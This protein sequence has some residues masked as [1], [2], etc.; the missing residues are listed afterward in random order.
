[1][2]TYLPQWAQPSLPLD[3]GLEDVLHAWRVH[4]LARGD[5]TRTIE[6]RIYTIRR[7][8]SC[9]I[10]PLTTD[11][12]ALLEWL[13]R[14]T[15]HRTGDAVRRSTRATY[16]S[17][18]RAFFRWAKASGRRDDDPSLELPSARAPRGVPRPTTPEG[19]Q[20]ILQACADS[21]AA[22]T[23]AYVLLGAY[24]GLRVHEIAQIRGEDCTD[25]LIF[26]TGKGGVESSIPMHP[27]VADLARRMPPTGP[28]FPGCD[29]GHVHRCSVSSAIKRAMRRAGVTG[30]PHALRHHYG[31]QVLRTSGDLRTAQRALRHASPAST[32]IYTQVADDALYRAIAG[33][34]A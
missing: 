17:Q 30:T 15:D 11:A 26:V 10:D 14:L 9:G 33:I 8:R 7:L 16:R 2:D 27:L 28:W 24:A 32:A 22:Q 3:A 13:A 18:L 34:P 31:T 6:S 20:A 4:G 5:S 21:R 12:D 23:R 29:R 25:G 19:V 1:M